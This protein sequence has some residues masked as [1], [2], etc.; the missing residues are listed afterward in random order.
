M[1]AITT[2]IQMVHENIPPQ[3]LDIGFREY[4][5]TSLN[6]VV[7][8]DERI[9][10]KVVRPRVLRDCNLVSGIAAKIEVNKCKI[11][12]IP[13]RLEHIIYVPHSITGGKSILSVL[14]LISNVIYTNALPGLN[15]LSTTNTAAKMYNNMASHSVI[16]TS[17]L[18]LI[19]ENTVLVTDPSI[20][21]FNSVLRCTLAYDKN[22]SSLNPRAYVAF[23]KL[24]ILAVK[25][26]IHNT[27]SI[28]LDQGYI[29]GG[30]ELSSITDVVSNYSEANEQY[31][32]YL[33]GE[34]RRVLYMQQPDNMNRY[35]AAMFGNIT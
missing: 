20:V 13:H 1:N 33:N 9:A 10:I 29:Y 5:N 25:A 3:I 24:V 16:Q 30:H 23:G 31:Y 11:D 35:I 26:Y 7:S 18:E 6:N 2:A 34:F 12:Y 14:E 21:V 17:K 22:M 28:Q 19:G 15:L 27:I 8:L 32:E 4:N